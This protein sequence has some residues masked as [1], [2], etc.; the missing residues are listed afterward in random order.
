LHLFALATD[1]D[2]TLATSGSVDAPTLKALEA[3]KASGRKLLLVTGRILSELRNV[4][5]KFNIG[6]VMVLPSN[7]NKATGLKAALSRWGLSPRNVVGIGDAENDHA[8]L[9]A[10]GRAVAVQNAIPA[11]KAKVDWITN[12]PRSA[13]VAELANLLLESDLRRDN[14]LA[15]CWARIEQTMQRRYTAP[16]K[17]D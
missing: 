13:G 2:G 15:V 10:C 17:A 16:A 7:V 11:L 3:V 8:L 12:A 9:M 6:A 1:Y 4:F 14:S 5:P